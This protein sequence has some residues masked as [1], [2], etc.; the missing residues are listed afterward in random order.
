MTPAVRETAVRRTEMTKADPRLER[1]YDY[2]KFHIGVYILAASTMVAIAG[3]ADS[4]DFIKDL[5]KHRSLLM[6]AIAMIG[7]AGGAG[8]VI[9]SSCAI[10]GTFDE[11]WNQRIGP[12]RLRIMSGWR[13]AIVEHGAFWLSA[14]LVAAA[15]LLPG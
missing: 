15:A 10:A 2:T 11:V 8:G 3:S 6:W 1:L 5:V 7:I 14:V 4:S 13:W 9:V 12:W